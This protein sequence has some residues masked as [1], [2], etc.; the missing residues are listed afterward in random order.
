MKNGVG[1]LRQSKL[2]TTFGPGAVLDLRGPSGAPL[3]GLLSGLEEW[4]ACAPAGHQG[5]AHQ[6]VIHEPR[7]QRRLIVDGFRLPPVKPER[8]KRREFAV[9]GTADV[10]PVVRFPVWLLCPRCNRLKDATAWS[11]DDGRPERRCNHHDGETVYVVPVRFIVACEDGHLDEFP[12]RRWIGCDC[13]RPQLRLQTAGAG[14]A[15]K[16]VLCVTRDCQ[17][18]PRSLEGVFGKGALASLGLKHCT[19]HRPWLP[20]P[21][22]QCQQVGRVVQRGASTV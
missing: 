20:L 13:S 16:L 18:R 5:L 17:S 1:E 21:P 7:L 8:L 2:V 15:G 14:L 12:W 11:G 6:Q 3:S 4:D 22:E 10:L 19:G 9:E